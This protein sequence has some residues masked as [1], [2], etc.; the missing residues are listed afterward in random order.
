[1]GSYKVPYDGLYEITVVFQAY[2]DRD[3]HI[4]LMVDGNKAAFIMNSDDAKSMNSLVLTRNLY[5]SSGQVVSVDAS[6][7]SNAYGSS[8]GIIGYESWFSG[9]LI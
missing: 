6:A 2:N 9:Q 7:M 1:M 4:E 3:I 5:L 8:H